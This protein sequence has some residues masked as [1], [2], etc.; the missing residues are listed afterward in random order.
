MLY[1]Y[2]SSDCSLAFLGQVF[3]WWKQVASLALFLKC[4]SEMWT[5]SGLSLEL[6]RIQ[7][8]VNMDS[9]TRKIEEENRGT[10]LEM[11]GMFGFT[12]DSNGLT[13]C[14]VWGDE[15]SNN[16]KSH[17]GTHFIT[18]YLGKTIHWTQEK[19]YPKK[20]KRNSVLNNMCLTTG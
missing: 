3:F 12:A 4:V 10:K 16:K 5:G 7:K 1:V 18:T 9:Q 13:L 15:L 11:T 6:R 8:G 20:E 14:L 17:W 2:M 19:I